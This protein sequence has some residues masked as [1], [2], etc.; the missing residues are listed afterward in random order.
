[1]N[2]LDRYIF[3]SVLLTCLGS[4]AL[5]AFV[6]M[7]GN[8]I[9]DLLGY[10]LRGQ[11]S[12]QTTGELIL[13]LLPF[14]VSYALPMGILTGVLLVLG[15]ISAD[16]EITAMRA[17]GISLLRIARPVV[18]LGV[19][20]CGVTLYVNFQSMPWAR[21]EYDRRLT[22]YVRADPARFIV[23]KTFIREF[24]GYVVYVGEK[25]GPNLGDFWLW[26]L[27][28]EGRA[29]NMVHAESGRIDYDKEKN[30]FIVT[31]TRA[32]VETRKKSTPGDMREP[33]SIPT[34]EKAE[35]YELSLDPILGRPTIRQKLQWMTYGELQATL[36]KRITEFRAAKP[37]DEQR[38]KERDVMQVRLVIQD[39][40]T[41]AVAVLSFAL[42]G[43]PLGVRVSRRETSAGLGLATLLA[44]GYYFL[45]IMVG[46]L[47]RHPEYRPDLLY[48]VPNLIFLAL[49]VRL[50]R[51]LERQ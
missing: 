26:Q 1:V 48:W 31:L 51:R 34:V 43:V 39:K 50:F 14:V 2:L 18:L 20:G 11:L 47:S 32:S 8:A 44:L 30:S 41:T 7:L 12:L 37:G 38:Q 4:V 19:L 42:I 45:T 36:A 27:D 16:S 46:W 3:R 49:A 10:L 33:P 21:V 35:P 17:N 23:P 24:P 9:R 25:Q 5:F 40:L 29:L 6:L 28:A 13:L 15:R 22:E